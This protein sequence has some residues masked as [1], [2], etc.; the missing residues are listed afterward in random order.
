[1]RAFKEA[2]FELCEEVHG[3]ELWFMGTTSVVKDIERMSAVLV[4][5]AHPL[6]QSTFCSHP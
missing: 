2:E 4:R 3:E 5:L 1:M 6:P